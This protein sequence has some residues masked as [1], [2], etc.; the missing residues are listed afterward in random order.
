[1]NHFRSLD[2][3]QV[4]REMSRTTYRATLTGSFRNHRALAHQIQRAAASVPANLAEGYGL[5]TRAQLIRCGRIALASSYEVRTHLEL[6]VEVG[7]IEP[8]H[9]REVIRLNHRTASLIIGY[10]KSL[11]R[12]R[13]TR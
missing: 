13:A 9:G 6:A 11:E 1:M 12:G 4:S 5:G 3:W 7:A 2:V 10:L 8:E